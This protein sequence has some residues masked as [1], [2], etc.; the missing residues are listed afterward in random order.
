MMEVE[1]ERLVAD[2]ETVSRAIVDH[3]GLAWEDACLEFHRTKRPVKTGSNVQVRMPLYQSSVGR[4]KPYEPHFSGLLAALGR[5]E[6]SEPG[7]KAS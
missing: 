1:Y 5:T 4:Y 7:Q 3:C 2:Q 6:V